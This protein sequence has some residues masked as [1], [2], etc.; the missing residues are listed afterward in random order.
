MATSHGGFALLTCSN[1]FETTGGRT[2]LC[3]GPP[4]G[5]PNLFVVLTLFCVAQVQDPGLREELAVVVKE[6][7]GCLFL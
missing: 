4:W 2:L 5:L 7:V 1:A 6:I 3:L